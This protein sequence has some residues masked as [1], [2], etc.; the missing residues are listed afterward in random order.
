MNNNEALTTLNGITERYAT[1]P[2]PKSKHADLTSLQADF[3]T[4]KGLKDDLIGNADYHKLLSSVGKVIAL[5][6]PKETSWNNI[7]ERSI[8]KILRP[9]AKKHRDVNG[10]ISW[11][12]KYGLHESINDH[13]KWTA[14]HFMVLDIIGYQYM[15]QLGNGTLPKEDRPLFHNNLDLEL[16]PDQFK[17]T[18]TDHEFRRFSGLDKIPSK[19]ILQLFEEIA[20][21]TF[22][23]N[24]PVRLPFYK[25]GKKGEYIFPMPDFNTFFS[26]D[27]VKES[28]YRTYEINFNSLLGQMFLHNLR[29]KNYDYI[30]AEFY[31]LPYSSQVF[32]RHFLINNNFPTISINLGNIIQALGFTFKNQT[33]LIK[34][35]KINVLDPLIKFGVIASYDFTK[36]LEDMKFVVKKK[37]NNSP[38]SGVEHK[39]KWGKA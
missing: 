1:I 22:K 16:K 25:D 32:Y 4:L 34:T 8:N 24:Y 26:I 5:M 37:L 21:A 9:Y 30:N 33:D 39:G 35:I 15:L 12:N 11:E 23:L 27:S 3:D 20:R 28:K 6:Q 18:I 19:N 17:V 10:I 38:Q 7:S 2:S 31:Q 13:A 29:M 14:R 36:G